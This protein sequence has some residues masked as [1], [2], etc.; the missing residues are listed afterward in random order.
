MRL[1]D[2]TAAFAAVLTHVAIL[3]AKREGTPDGESLLLDRR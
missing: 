2:S 3:D 1:G